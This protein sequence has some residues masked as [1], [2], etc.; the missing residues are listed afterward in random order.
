[1]ISG[2]TMTCDTC[3]VPAYTAHSVCRE[4]GGHFCQAHILPGSLHEETGRALCL[5]CAV[6]FP[7]SA[8]ELIR[9]LS[10]AA[11]GLE[12]AQRFREV[13]Q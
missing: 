5:T 1:M 3:G 13:V 7:Q 11:R 10:I 12:W 2:L 6:E 8:G 9:M 4:C